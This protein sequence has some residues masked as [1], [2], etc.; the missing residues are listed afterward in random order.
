MN[1]TETPENL[2]P[3]AFAIYCYAAIADG[4]DAPTLVAN[5]YDQLA[6]R[7]R[8]YARKAAV[9]AVS[10]WLPRDPGNTGLLCTVMTGQKQVPDDEADLIAHLLRGYSSRERGDT[11][12]VDK[13]VEFLDH[14]SLI[15][16]EVALGN[17]IAFFDPEAGKKAE[18]GGLNVAARGEPGYDKALKA[19]KAWAEEMKKK[20]AEK[21]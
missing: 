11:T 18:L 10:N 20:I 1:Y 6:D 15:V 4:P 9:M 7:N 2:L 21:K 13:L 3:I 14:P 17:L 19:W 12:A 16:R 5:L 8:H